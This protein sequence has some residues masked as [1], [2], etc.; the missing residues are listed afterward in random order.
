MKEEKRKK[1]E[2]EK[3]K[4]AESEAKLA[5]EQARQQAASLFAQYIGPIRAKVTNSWIRQEQYD[6]VPEQKF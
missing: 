3:R 4:Q 6:R 2:Q 5:Q 1:A